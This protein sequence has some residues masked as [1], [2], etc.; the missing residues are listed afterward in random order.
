MPLKWI[1][2]T[3]FISKIKD[4]GPIYTLLHDLIKLIRSQEE[5]YFSLRKSMDLEFLHLTVCYTEKEFQVIF[6]ILSSESIIDPVS[7]YLSN[8]YHTLN[9]KCVEINAQEDIVNLLV[10]EKGQL[11]S[12]KTVP[13]GLSKHL[14]EDLEKMP[15]HGRCFSLTVPELF[16]QHQDEFIASLSDLKYNKLPEEPLLDSADDLA[17]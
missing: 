15:M 8:S 17:F 4:A 2:N 9:I 6:H 11:Q 1:S 5:Q 3:I 13:K 7:S 12:E 10:H 16:N 14:I